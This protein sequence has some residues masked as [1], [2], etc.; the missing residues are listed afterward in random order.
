MSISL[1]IA[2]TLDDYVLETK[3]DT[4]V[5]KDFIDLGNQPNSLNQVFALDNAAPAGR[6]Y[7]LKANG[8]YPMSANPQTPARPVV[9]AGATGTPVVSS[10]G[11]A[12]PII[13][14]YSG[15]A[16][17]INFSDDLTI[18]NC[19][20]YQ[21]AADGTLGWA[22][23]GASTPG[24][25]ITLDNCLME[26]TRWV[27]VQSNDAV[28][29][30]L[31]IKDCYF[32]NMTG[33]P[34]R[35]NGGVYDNVNHN[36][37]EIVVEN[38]THVMAQGM[39]YKFRNYPVGKAWF[40]HNTFVN[41]GNAVFENIGYLS[42]WV[43]TNNIF[44][45][46]NVQP[47]N[48]GLDFSETDADS[49]PTGIINVRDLPA[50]YEQLDRKI[51]VDKNVV[52]W[53]PELSDVV[54]K[55]SA[56]GSNGTSEWYDQMITMNARTQAMFDDNGAYPYL[57]EGVWYEQ[58]PAFADPQDLFTDQLAN[59]E[60]F[61]VATVDESSTALLPVWRLIYTGSEDYIYSD[62]PI[63]INLSYSDAN[64]LTGGVGGF[65]VG[66]LNWFPA[67]KA[68]WLLQR[69]AENEELLAALNEGRTP[70]ASLVA[71]T[72]GSFEI[73][74]VGN[75]VEGWAFNLGNNAS[76]DFVIVHDQVK[77]GAN[78]LAITV[79]SLGTNRWD[80]EALNAPVPVVP[81]ERYRYSIW[82]KASEAGATA[83]FTVGNPSF[84][85][86]YR[87]EQNGTLTTEWKLF[88]GEFTIPAN[89]VAT[90]RAPIHFNFTE[91]VGK[92]VYI[93][94]LRIT[95]VSI[96]GVDDG[97]DPIPAEYRLSQN[98]PNP[99][100]PTTVIEYAVEKPSHV[101][102]KVFNALGQEVATLV[103]GYHTAG[104]SYKVN[105]DASGLANG[106]Y[107][108]TMKAGDTH[109]SK[110]MILMK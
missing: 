109:L 84:A 8:Y 46:C 79:N 92:T 18:K 4:L 39:I 1:V 28:D 11:D 74:P 25:K 29:T 72:N 10:T 31:H 88:S 78:A 34:C 73:P 2:Q 35:R 49:L 65:P 94:S 71:N 54:S 22:F 75:A 96:T 82:A 53:S 47:Y 80:I 40:N 56:A 9:I 90:A 103:D 63:P 102:L 86:R 110:K 14:G 13:S 23:F 48:K 93:D 24:R 21:I 32:V 7:E 68:E 62:W 41:M 100:N 44:V 99:F 83:H 37:N 3:G 77:D 97:D 19:A 101:T 91:N 20:V 67:E 6:V 85:E 106:L 69:D 59:F 42:N 81:G 12:P 89:D 51:L 45:N 58:M 76:A 61:C 15:N 66:D 98:Y 33:E 16:G 43:V 95:R 104:S 87:N 38:S 30:K 105:F 52:A 26:H 107:V 108:Y 27:M 36:T 64:L 70:G 17:A 50:E 5:I 55:V 57:T 60:D